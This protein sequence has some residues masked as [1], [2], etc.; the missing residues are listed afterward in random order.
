LPMNSTLVCALAQTAVNAIT[1][2]ANVLATNFII[3]LSL[4]WD[5]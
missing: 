1:I 5:L 2:A 3:S 4:Y